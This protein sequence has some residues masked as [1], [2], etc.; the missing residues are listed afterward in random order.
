MCLYDL[1]CVL[2]IANLH[3]DRGSTCD[4]TGID[5]HISVKELIKTKD[6]TWKFLIN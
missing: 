5:E 2:E 6:N 1:F 4:F 3:R